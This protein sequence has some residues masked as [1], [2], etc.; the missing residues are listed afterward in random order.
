MT[1]QIKAGRWYALDLGWTTEVASLSPVLCKQNLG[2]LIC[3]YKNIMLPKANATCSNR[4]KL[5]LPLLIKSDKLVKPA[6]A[7]VFL[8]SNLTY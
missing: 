5:S 6:T 2:R 1:G 7:S 4:I 8:T 3:E